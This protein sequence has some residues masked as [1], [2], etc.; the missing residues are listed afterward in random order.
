LQKK[1]NDKHLEIQKLQKHND[2]LHN[3]NVKLNSKIKELNQQIIQTEDELKKKLYEVQDELKKINIDKIMEEDKLKN[4]IY[5]LR[6]EIIT[7]KEKVENTNL[8][9]QLLKKG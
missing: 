6:K 7:M 8:E 9:K 2:E 1:I 5:K 4:E 3:E